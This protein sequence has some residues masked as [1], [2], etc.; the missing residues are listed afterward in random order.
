MRVKKVNNLPK[1]TQ[2]VSGRFRIPPPFL[3]TNLCFFPSNHLENFT[4]TKFY[5]FFS[6][7]LYIIAFLIWIVITYFLMF[8]RLFGPL[9]LLLKWSAPGTNSALS[10]WQWTLVMEDSDW[11]WCQ[12]L[13]PLLPHLVQV[14][15]LRP[16]YRVVLKIKHRN[17]HSTLSTAPDK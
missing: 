1:G 15:S 6:N 12:V 16:T 8:Y 4:F 14:S 11:A 10:P 5:L 7:G 2:L 9:A 3:T 17:M 13:A